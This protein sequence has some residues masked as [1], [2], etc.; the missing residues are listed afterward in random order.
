MSSIA[1][2]CS[3]DEITEKQNSKAFSAA[4]ISE[5]LLDINDLNNN[6][7]QIDEMFSNSQDLTNNGLG[8]L[9]HDAGLLLGQTA[10]YLDDGGK[11]GRYR[12]IH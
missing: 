7:M 11:P 1:T 9:K 12:P 3:K 6:Y 5:N 2:P 8:S 4:M 10:D